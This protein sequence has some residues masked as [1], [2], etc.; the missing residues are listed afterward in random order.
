MKEAIT[1]R[2]IKCRVNTER[3]HSLKFCF[4]DVSLAHPSPS[5][6]ELNT[7]L[8]ASVIIINETQFPP[9]RNSRSNKTTDLK[10]VI[11]MQKVSSDKWA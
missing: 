7:V 4:L 2:I 6:V 11:I 9:S 5:P 3:K 10:P 1:V 8:D